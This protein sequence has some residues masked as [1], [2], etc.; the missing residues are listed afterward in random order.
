MRVATSAEVEQLKHLTGIVPSE[1][2]LDKL[3][4]A[5]KEFANRAV[6]G[7][8]DFTPQLLVLARDHTPAEPTITAFAMSGGFST[9]IEKR[10]ALLRCGRIMQRD[11][12]APMAA[13]LV[14]AAWVSAEVQGEQRK[15]LLPEDDPER[16]EVLI[17]VALSCDA[18]TRFWERD[19][20]R[21]AEQRMGWQ[22]DWRQHGDAKF[23]LIESF[24]LGWMTAVEM[25]QTKRR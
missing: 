1:E 4:A 5:G 20:Q 23:P 13:M 6:P 18:H 21:D 7:D 3:V 2:D 12:K 17:A 15:Y 24:Y 22:G 11:R 9:A 19:I 25:A 16:R 10:A 14:S 8:R